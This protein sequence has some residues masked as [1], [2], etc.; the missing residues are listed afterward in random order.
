MPSTDAPRP[1][2]VD[3]ALRDA[4]DHAVEARD[5]QRLDALL[6]PLR[7]ASSA[8]LISQERLLFHRSEALRHDLLG[9]DVAATRAFLEKQTVLPNCVPG[10]GAGLS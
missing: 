3:A 4:I 6:A 1:I 9:D 10:G 8:T 5:P 7:A 2:A